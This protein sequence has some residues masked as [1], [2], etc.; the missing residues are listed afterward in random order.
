ME[1]N[2][3]LRWMGRSGA[4]V[5]W[6]AFVAGLIALGV[7]F[8]DD[9]AV[10][11][12]LLALGPLAPAGY[13]FGE[14]AQIVL[15]PIPGQPFEVSGGWLL[16]FWPGVLLGSAAAI[17]GSILSFMLGRRYGT[18][19]VHRHIPEEIRRKF[20]SRL[21]R[22]RRAEWIV[23]GLMLVPSFPRDPLCHLAGVSSMSTRSFVLVAAIGRP[24]GLIP[25]VALGADGVAAGIVWQAAMIGAAAVL[26]GGAHLA[27]R[28][29]RPHRTPAPPTE[30][31]TP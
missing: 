21:D 24:V 18:G 16:G 15:W 23:F 26:Y 31:T 5:V 6:V 9:D 13:V 1:S 4:L 12:W 30:A 3:R 17:A 20:S 2:S 22:G 27:R 14:V 25:W 19:W 11:Q 10:R 8:P 7:F 28:L 29:R